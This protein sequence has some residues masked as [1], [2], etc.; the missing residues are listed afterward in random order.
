MTWSRIKQR[1]RYPKYSE[2]V[3]NDIMR[4]GGTVY[5]DHFVV[6]VDSLFSRENAL[7]FLNLRIEFFSL[8]LIISLDSKNNWSAFDIK[9][10]EKPKGYGV[11]E[12]T[13]GNVMIYKN[14]ILSFALFD[15]KLFV[16]VMSLDSK[17]FLLS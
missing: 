8:F 13:L 2:D 11:D 15:N 10:L 14:L 5:K 4:F 1:A 12:K 16:T 6:L 7:Y 3:D 17:D 9:G